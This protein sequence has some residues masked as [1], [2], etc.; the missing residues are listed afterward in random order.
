M[1][2]LLYSGICVYLYGSVLKI[3]FE[4]IPFL[5]VMLYDMY[6]DIADILFFVLDMYYSLF[7]QLHS[8]SINKFLPSVEKNLILYINICKF[9]YFGSDLVD[10]VVSGEFDF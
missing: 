7:L 2:E 1:D 8:L 5:R 4:D 6:N 10:G 9:L 3:E